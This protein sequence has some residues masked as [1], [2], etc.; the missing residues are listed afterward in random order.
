[1]MAD[2][3]LD[4]MEFG[5]PPPPEPVKVE[6][7]VKEMPEEV[8]EEIQPTKPKVQEVSFLRFSK[9]QELVKTDEASNGEIL[10]LYAIPDD[11]GNKYLVTSKDGLVKSFTVDSET[12]EFNYTRSFYVSQTGLACTNLLSNNESMVLASSNEGIANPLKAQFQ[13]TGDTR[14]IILFSL[15]TG[16]TISTFPAHENF[17]SGLYV[18]GNLMMSCSHDSTLKLWNLLDNTEPP[19]IIYDHEDFV[20]SA[21]LC[22]GYIVSI[23]ALGII[24]VR[25][26]K[27]LNEPLAKL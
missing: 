10:S 6:E 14:C 9:G 24:I 22:E 20:L 21:D 13:D 25:Q 5:M 16:T 11:N 4:P 3:M 19:R 17:I 23:D 12:H 2:P 27:A 26:L 18:D 15:L 1:M 7:E 8:V